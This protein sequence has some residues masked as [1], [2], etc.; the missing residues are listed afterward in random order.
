M[1]QECKKHPEK[2]R[3]NFMMEW[4]EPVWQPEMNRRLNRDPDHPTFE[5][6]LSVAF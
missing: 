4:G 1:R 5:K 6:L 3:E 2:S